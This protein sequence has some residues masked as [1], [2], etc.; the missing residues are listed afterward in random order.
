MG[1]RIV[2]PARHSSTRLPG[3]PLLDICGKPMVL[4]VLDRAL[5]AGADEVWVAMRGGGELAFDPSAAL[6]L[7]D[8][9]VVE[10][11][12]VASRIGSAVL[13]A[14]GA[15]FNNLRLRIQYLERTTD[16]AARDVLRPDV[17]EIG[18]AHV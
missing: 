8:D 3:K 15:E 18:R 1:F 14:A 2:I 17:F 13:D 5:E 12:I 10:R 6:G 11:K 4:R 9:E 16:L 7:V